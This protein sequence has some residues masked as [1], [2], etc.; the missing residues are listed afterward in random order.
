[1]TLENLG[2]GCGWKYSLLNSLVVIISVVLELAAAA[3]VAFRSDD[4]GFGSTTLQ[5]T[6]VNCGGGG[7]VVEEE[8]QVRRLELL[9][10][11]VLVVVVMSVEVGSRKEEERLFKFPIV[12]SG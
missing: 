7:V 5:A 1:M 4:E 6:Q 8:F 12:V 9:A 11:V 10:V 2:V 3:E